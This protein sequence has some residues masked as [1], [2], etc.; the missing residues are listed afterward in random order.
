MD[1]DLAKVLP[2]LTL[3][4]LSDVPTA[5][6]ASAQRFAAAVAP[7]TQWRASFA[8]RTIPSARN[9]DGVRVRVY[10][11]EGRSGSLLGCA[12]FFHGGGYILG[13]LETDHDRC[14]CYA[15]EAGCVVVSV[16]YRL[17]PEHPYPD[18]LDDCYAAVE[19]A[20]SARE[21][22]GVDPGRLA[23]AGSSAG[24]GLAAAVAIRARDE[25]G[26]A[27]AFQMMMQPSLDDRLETTSMAQ[28]VG[29]PPWD[30]TAS[31]QMWEIYLGA[32]REERAHVPATAAPSPRRRPVGAAARL[33]HDRRARPA[34]RRGQR[35]RAPAQR[36]GRA[37]RAPPVPRR[38][39]RLRP[40]GARRRRRAPCDRGA[41]AG[42][43][44]SPRRRLTGTGDL[45]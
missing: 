3:V 15:S 45:R 30:A 8:D 41:G 44:A 9:E 35:L 14:L 18:G 13:D 20:V 29:V 42:A 4:D 27:L 37:D 43:P 19:W 33:H 25:G 16:D 21:E 6:A 7:P 24:G 11:P 39:P 36:G 12:V 5:R 40:S 10:Q 31:R 32:S 1:P 22:L 23:V 2:T 26:P 17:A 38:V 28:F 34:A